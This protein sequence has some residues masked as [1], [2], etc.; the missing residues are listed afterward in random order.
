MPLVPIQIV[1]NTLSSPYDDL[2]SKMI[3][4]SNHPEFMSAWNIIAT[5]GNLFFSWYFLW[6]LQLSWVG[7]ILAGLPMSYA[8]T[9]V[10]W[11]YMKK[12]VINLD[13]A[14]FKNMAYQCYIAPLIGG[15]VFVGWIELIMNV[16][17]PVISPPF[18]GKLV[19]VPA[20]IAILLLFFGWV[21]IYYPIISYFGFWDKYSLLT[22]KRAVALSGPS[23]WLIWWT[24]K[25]FEYFHNKS[26]FKDKT[27]TKLAA[28]AEIERQE[29]AVI[30]YKKY[31]KVFTED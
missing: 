30:R 20:A 31:L 8:G 22:Y 7:M 15:V 17:W 14:W 13:R 18:P 11:I 2:A 23:L 16:L 28:P 19:L 24:Y 25:I 1:L 12:H 26:P 29:L 27:E 9:I 10:K 3:Y 4:I 21:F 5:I 6:V